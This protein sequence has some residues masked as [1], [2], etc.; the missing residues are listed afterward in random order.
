[1]STTTNTGGKYIPVISHYEPLHL[2]PTSIFREVCRE[3]QTL[4][5]IHFVAFMNGERGGVK[6]VGGTSSL[7]E[8][9]HHFRPSEVLFVAL[10]WLP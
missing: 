8:L 7:T 5:F 1:M 10:D 2:I 6:R 4:F 9:N 3:R